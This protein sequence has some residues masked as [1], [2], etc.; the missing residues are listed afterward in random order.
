MSQFNSVHITTCSRKLI[1][2]CISFK[3]IPSKYIS[4]HNCS[5]PSKLIQQTNRN[6]LGLATVIISN[7]PY[8]SRSSFLLFLMF[9]GSGY[10]SGQLYYKINKQIIIIIIIIII[11][12]CPFLGVETTFHNHIK[13][14]AFIYIRYGIPQ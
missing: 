12:L 8:K 6:R 1:F 10:F 7:E 9:L 4:Q 11:I 13:R 3:C 2:S 14:L 5:S